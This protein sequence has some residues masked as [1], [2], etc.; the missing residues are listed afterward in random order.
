MRCKP[1]KNRTTIR[2]ADGVTKSKMGFA[3]ALRCHAGASMVTFPNRKH[4]KCGNLCQKQCRRRNQSLLLEFSILDLIF[5]YT[6]CVFWRT[7]FAARF[8]LTT[9]RTTCLPW[10]SA[11]IAGAGLPNTLP[12]VVGPTCKMFFFFFRRSGKPLNNAKHGKK[13]PG[14]HVAKR[15]GGDFGVVPCETI[16]FERQNF[17][18]E[19]QKKS[20]KAFKLIRFINIWIC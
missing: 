12:F 3:A 7:N 11:S 18:K 8:P 5:L 9:S 1:R 20:R 10:L 19:S 13:N 16:A 6:I 17:Y 15:L 4:G 14:G 2:F